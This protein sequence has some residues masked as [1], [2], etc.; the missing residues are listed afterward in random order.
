MY[1]VL[2]YGRMTRDGVRMDAYARAIAAAVKPGDVVVDLGAGTGIFSVLAAKAGARVVHAIE[3]NPAVLLLPEIAK[4]NG[5]ADR[6]VVHHAS[7][8]DV[9]LDERAD[10]IVSDM[11]GNT[12]L[13]GAHIPAI[14]DARDR[15]L[16]PGGVLVPMADTLFVALVENEDI[17]RF[18]AQASESFERLGVR[19]S[20]MRVSI[21]NAV[22]DDRRRPLVASDLLSTAAPWATLDYATCDAATLEGVVSLD[23]TRGG[24]A[25]GLA[26]W[27]EARV[28]PGIAYA[29]GP[30]WDLAY[31]RAYLPLLEPVRVAHGDVASVTLRADARGA[32]WAW[33]TRI[34]RAGAVLASARQSTFLGDPAAPAELLRLSPS[35]RPTLAPAGRDARAILDAI[36][37]ERTVA[38]LVDVLGASRGEDAPPRARED[39]LE[40]V[41]SVLTRYG[42]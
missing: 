32:R 29:S 37:G 18:H 15:M 19:A 34:T 14:L 6:I 8:L 4:E 20:A 36:D 7:S 38:E 12:P 5:V 23:V 26:V 16:A 10:V 30:G 21:A 33:D 39:L 13:N 3:P 11:R 24:T 42:R 17:A 9:T 1:S 27:F 40:T 28:A 31:A 22:Y 35:A 2:D 41:R 25:H